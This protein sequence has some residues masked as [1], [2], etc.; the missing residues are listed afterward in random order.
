MWQNEVGKTL[1]QRNMEPQTLQEYHSA[2]QKSSKVVTARC[3]SLQGT[4]LREGWA[5]G[6]GGAR[7]RCRGAVGLSA[8]GV[9]YM[10]DLTDTTIACAHRPYDARPPLGRGLAPGH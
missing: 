1:H 6:G 2:L 3:R 4:A 10:S 9:G 7:V 5:G 8:P